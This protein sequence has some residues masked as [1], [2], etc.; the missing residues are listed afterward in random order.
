MEEQ[1]N[2]QSNSVGSDPKPSNTPLIY[3]G[4]AF[5]LLGLSVGVFAGLSNSQVIGVLLPLLF[6]LIGGAN[7]IYLSQVDLN[8]TGDRRRLSLIGQEQLT[9]TFEHLLTLA[10]QID[11]LLSEPELEED[12]NFP[13]V[14][15][16]ESFISLRLYQYQYLVNELPQRN[17]PIED[18]ADFID[19][20]RT[21][22]SG[23]IHRSRV[24]GE[25]QLNLWLLDHPEI[26]QKLWE[27]ELAYLGTAYDMR[28]LDWL[29]GQPLAET[30][31]Q[32]I[33]TS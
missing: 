1:Q 17:V 25:S 15:A 27:L 11:T 6:G 4:I 9:S 28:D 23:L 13:E 30:I 32:L 16:I 22:F 18:L 24:A 33:Q 29:S 31:D 8:K 3:Y 12:G 5:A 26:R 21:T 20:D 2:V 7:G 14:W 10:K 19:E